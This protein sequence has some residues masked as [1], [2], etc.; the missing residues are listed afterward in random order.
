MKRTRVLVVDDHP[1]VRDW[2][3]QLIDREADLEVCG[4]AANASQ[5]LH[6]IP[7]LKPDLA[8]LDLAMEGSLGMD[9]IK[10]IK[11]RHEALPVLVLSMHDES[12]YAERAIRAGAAGYVTKQ[13]AAE[14][15]LRA[16]R[17]VLNGEIYV[18]EKVA[19]KL[20]HSI[21][22]GRTGPPASH[23]DTLS[24]RQLDVLRLMGRGYSTVQIAQELHLSVK[25]VE[26]YCARIKEK[27]NLQTASELRQYAIRFTKATGD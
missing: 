3:T 1:M 20:L 19:G 18:S 8:I 2:L 5:T 26:S 21:T 7:K 24:D 25:T 9:L 10:E 11:S 23:V 27:L 6:A 12:L 15:I 4:E 14:N 17:G 13:E 16:I 22:R